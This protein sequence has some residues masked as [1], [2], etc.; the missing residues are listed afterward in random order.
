MFDQPKHPEIKYY[1]TYFG[2]RFGLFICFDMIFPHPGIDLLQLGIRHFTFPTAWTNVPPLVTATQYQQGWSRRFE[3]TLLAANDALDYGNSGSG[4]Y[5]QGEILTSFF[6]PSLAGPADEKLLIAKVP[7]SNNQKPSNYPKISSNN[8][9]QNL[10]AP[11]P[12]KPNTPQDLN[13]LKQVLTSSIFV[14]RSSICGIVPGGCQFFYAK[15]GLK[16]N[17]TAIDNNITCRAS[18]SISSCD[19]PG[20]PFALA[21]I[22]SWIFFSQWIGKIQKN[23]Y[24]LFLKQNYRCSSLWNYTMYR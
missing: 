15:P 16:G 10:V 17:L 12:R 24:Y 18:F 21:A 11:A 22:S 13:Q 23:K 2:V 14:N 19:K 6:D 20:E 5:H 9:T 3:A 8:N 4:I 7:I 1:D